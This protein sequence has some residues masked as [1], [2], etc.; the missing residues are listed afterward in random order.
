MNTIK[1]FVFLEDKTPP[2]VNYFYQSLIFILLGGIAAGMLYLFIYLINHTNIFILIG[3]IR[4]FYSLS[5]SNKIWT[6]KS[7]SDNE[8]AE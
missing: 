4:K 6:N 7:A 8:S 3:N 1:K 2:P 5:S